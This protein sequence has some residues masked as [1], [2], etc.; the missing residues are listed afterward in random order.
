MEVSF[1]VRFGGQSEAEANSGDC[2]ERQTASESPGDVLSISPV[3]LRGLKT[4]MAGLVNTDLTLK[5]L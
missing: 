2:S 3:T 1:T 5:T 4:P